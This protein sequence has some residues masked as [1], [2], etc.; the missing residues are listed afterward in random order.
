MNS[1]NVLKVAFGNFLVKMLLN[2]KGDLS[3]GKLGGAIVSLCGALIAAPHVGIYLPEWITHW[4]FIV[5]WLGAALGF[6]GFRDAIGA[7]KKDNNNT[8][9]PPKP[10]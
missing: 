3:F 7:L 4:A 6:A 8:V 5:V 9:D 2:E 1:W 10:L